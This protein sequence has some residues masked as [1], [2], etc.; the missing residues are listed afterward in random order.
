MARIRV[1][2]PPTDAPPYGPI[3]ILP[4]DTF[5]SIPLML[6]FRTQEGE[7][8]VLEPVTDAKLALRVSW[9]STTEKPAISFGVEVHRLVSGPF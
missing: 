9:R 6:T 5:G 7:Y 1:A 3:D 2:L 4:S 8:L